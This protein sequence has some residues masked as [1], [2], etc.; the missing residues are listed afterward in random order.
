[1]QIEVE[2]IDGILEEGSEILEEYKGVP[3]VD[4]GEDPERWPEKMKGFA[5]GRGGRPDEIAGMAAFLASDRASYISGTVIT[6][7]GGWSARAPV[8]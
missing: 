5:F 7:D 3:A 2:A 8:V 4:A 6:I 1:M